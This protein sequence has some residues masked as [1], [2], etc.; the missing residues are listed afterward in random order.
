MH[1]C[2]NRNCVN[3]EHLKLGTHAENMYDSTGQG[4]TKKFL[5][6]Q[7]KEKHFSG[8]HRLYAEKQRILKTLG[9]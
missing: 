6:G 3:P 9:I 7:I 5:A 8:A 2:D 4:Q 1:I